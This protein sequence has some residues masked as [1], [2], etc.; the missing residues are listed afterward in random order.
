VVLRAPP[1]R[2]GGVASWPLA[3]LL[4]LCLARRTSLPKTKLTEAP[5]PIPTGLTWLRRPHHGFEPQGLGEG[6]PMVRVCAR[7]R[8]WCVSSEKGGRETPSWLR[9]AVAIMPVA[10]AVSSAA[11][12][13]R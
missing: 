4:L 1:I 7:V 3:S 2:Q 9:C 11:R 6:V 5:L 8:A 10:L 13:H 12:T